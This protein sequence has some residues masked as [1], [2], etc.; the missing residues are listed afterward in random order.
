MNQKEQLSKQKTEWINSFKEVYSEKNKK[1][2]V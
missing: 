2:K 1:K